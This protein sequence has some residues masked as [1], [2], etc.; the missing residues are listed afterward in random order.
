MAG[1][2]GEAADVGEEDGDVL[3]LLDVNAPELLLR[4][5]PIDV[6]LHVV[7]DVL[8]QDGEENVLLLLVVPH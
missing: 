8:G 5:R 4:L 6:L 1:Q 3:V 2:V 7:G